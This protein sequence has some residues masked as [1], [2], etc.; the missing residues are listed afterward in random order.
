MNTLL[1]LLLCGVCVGLVTLWLSAAF[2]GRGRRWPGRL[3]VVGLAITSG[4]CAAFLG[5]QAW[6]TL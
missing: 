6:L 1:W 4:F 5:L 3:G 2:A